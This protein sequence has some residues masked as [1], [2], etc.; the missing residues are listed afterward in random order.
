MKPIEPAG[1]SPP[2]PISPGVTHDD[3]LF[4]SGQVP[5]EP[6]SG[7]ILGDDVETQTE[8]VLEN[9]ESVLNEADASLDDV[10]KTQVFLA[11]I[12]DFD[13]MNEAYETIVPEPYPARS[14]VEVGGLVGDILVEIEAIAVVDRD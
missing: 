14:A 7:R 9:L 2:V 4:V 8:A 3:L 5:Q 12:A 10:V 6:D 1:H 11:D 13:G